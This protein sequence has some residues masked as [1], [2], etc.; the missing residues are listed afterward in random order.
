MRK[1]FTLLETVVVIAIIG[2]L[3]AILTPVF[4]RVKHQARITETVQHLHQVHIALD[5]YRTDY[6]G[7][8]RLGD[9]S[10]MG[11]PQFDYAVTSPIMS[12]LLRKGP[13]LANRGNHIYW[14]DSLPSRGYGDTWIEMIDI[15]EDRTPEYTTI[16]C[17]PGEYNVD[18]VFHPKLGLGV[19]VNGSLVRHLKPGK[20][21]SNPHWWTK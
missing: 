17:T 21:D 9:G 12:L 14:P 13:C 10:Q 15:F 18:N 6:D 4:A 20:H 8:G 3:A 2:V 1:A 7:Q 5:I 11:Y 19:L 16:T